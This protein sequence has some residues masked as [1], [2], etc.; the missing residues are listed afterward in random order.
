MVSA[1]M[2]PLEPIW[3]VTRFLFCSQGFEGGV[4]VP[5]IWL[6]SLVR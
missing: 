5:H 4:T 6:F 1:D 2:K 3:R